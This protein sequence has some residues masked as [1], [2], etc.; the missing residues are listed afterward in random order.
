MQRFLHLRCRDFSTAQAMQRAPC[1]LWRLFLQAAHPKAKCYQGMVKS[2]TAPW[3]PKGPES[4]R[5]AADAGDF[6]AAYF[7]AMLL[8]H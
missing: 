6:V 4:L 2:V 3:D 8:Y 5:E 7:L 1:E